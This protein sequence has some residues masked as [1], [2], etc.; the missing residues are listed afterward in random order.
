MNPATL[1]ED[2]GIIRRRYGCDE[3]CSK[4]DARYV[5]LCPEC[6]GLRPDDCSVCETEGKMRGYK[7][8]VRCPAYYQSRDV[9]GALRAY[10]MMK[11]GFL[12]SPDGVANQPAPFMQFTRIFGDELARIHAEQAESGN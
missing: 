8:M 3:P 11:Q 10:H 9:S 4:K 5:I 12:P 1:P 6:D 7:M 2:V